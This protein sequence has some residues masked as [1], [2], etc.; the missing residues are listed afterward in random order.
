MDPS[1]RP[2][3]P[4]RGDIITA[5]AL[6][7]VT[8]ALLTTTMMFVMSVPTSGSLALYIAAI[9][10][11]ASVPTWLIGLCL[12]GGPSWWWLHRRGFRSPGA[13]VATGA[14]LTGLAA[15]AVLLACGDRLPLDLVESPW[16]AFTGLVLIGALVGLQTV[17]FAYRTKGASLQDDARSRRPLNGLPPDARP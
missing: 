14:V 9:T 15:A 4:T 17:A 6:G 1:P 11:A 10:V 13:G 8:G 5:L 2:P 16:G 7:V 12:V 3:R